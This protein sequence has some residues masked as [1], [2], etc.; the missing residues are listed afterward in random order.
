M[1]KRGE[2]FRQFDDKKKVCRYESGGE[3]KIV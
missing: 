1:K 2:L 3:L